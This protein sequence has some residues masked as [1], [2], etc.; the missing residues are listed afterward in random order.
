MQLIFHDLVT[1]VPE[2]KMLFPRANHVTE[3]DLKR[4][5]GLTTDK[6]ETIAKEVRFCTHCSF[7]LELILFTY[8]LCE[9]ILQA[10]S[11]AQL[12]KEYGLD[13]P[14]DQL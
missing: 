6:F 4:L 1:K 11:L 13:E 3:D 12:Y 8:I 5:G 2:G 14:A 7:T 10:K 9:T